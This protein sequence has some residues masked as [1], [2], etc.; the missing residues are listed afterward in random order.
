MPTPAEGSVNLT[1]IGDSLFVS[2]GSVSDLTAPVATNI[3]G[4]AHLHI[5]YAGENGPVA[6]P[7]DIAFDPSDNSAALATR[8][9]FVGDNPALAEAMGQG[10][11]YV[12]VHTLAFPGGEVR[13][14]VV[15]NF[16]L[17]E[18]FDAMLYGEQQNP[19]ILTDGMGGVVI[20]VTRDSMFVS[21]AFAL[22][23]PL[24]PIG[25]TGLH[26]HSG[27]F[28]QNGAVVLPLTADVAPDSLSGVLARSANAFARD[29]A[30]V[31]AMRE[32]SVYVNVHSLAYPAG[33]VRGQVVGYG[34]S[35]YHSYVSYAD[36]TPFPDAGA[37]LRVL[38][39]KVA[40]S[41]NV[42]YS[43]SYSGWGGL[44]AGFVPFLQLSNPQTGAGYL[45]FPAADQRDGNG[46]SGIIPAT[47]EALDADG[48]AGLF[49]R[50]LTRAGFATGAGSVLFD[51]DFA[52]ECKRVF[53]AQT[54]AS[55]VVPNSS[56]PEGGEVYVEYYG[57]R[58]AVNAFIGAPGATVSGLGLNAGLAGQVGDPLIGINAIPTLNFVAVLPAQNNLAIEP[59]TAARLRD[60]AVYVELA[61]VGGDET[62]LRGQLLPRANVVYH[63]PLAAGQAVPG[64]GPSP[65]N[66]AIVAEVTGQRVNLSGS[67]DELAGGFNPA[68]AGG[69]H[70]HG[71]IAGRTGGIIAP[72][73]TFAASGDTAGEFFAQDNELTASAGLLDSM[74]RRQVYVNLHSLTR[75]AGELRGQVA[76]LANHVVHGKLSPDV[77]LPYTGMM[78]AS[79]GMGHIH[80]EVFDTTLVLSGSWDSLSTAVDVSIGGG[81]HMHAGSVA[82]T[83]GILFPIAF[84]GESGLT[85]ATVPATDNVVAL[86]PP[87]VATLVGGDV[88]ANVHTEAAP[89]G[90][91]R[92]QMLRS[93]NEYPAASPGFVFPTAGATVDLNAGDTSSVA[94]IDWED[95]AANDPEQDIA[96]VWQLYADTTAAPAFQTEINAASETSLTFVAIDGLLGS[97]GVG[98][99][100]S[101]TAYH[102]AW[103]T[104]GSLLTPGPLTEVTFRRFLASATAELPAGAVALVNSV[105]DGGQ[106]LLDVNDLPGGRLHYEIANAAG[107]RVGGRAFDHAGAAQRYTLAD[108]PTQ[109]GIYTLA[110][111]DAEGRA[112][113]WMFV[114]R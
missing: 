97:L 55:Q 65:A 76:P 58:I 63:A 64:Q 77:T 59:D 98:L 103:T 4:G 99:G 2:S 81:A 87:Q 88:Y 83:G 20:E 30:L 6:L 29:P 19:P 89:S 106:L 49:G 75:P 54:T 13:G 1:L 50:Y 91:I 85:A 23:A 73:V 78:G 82:E 8:A 108:A 62:A 7:I 27:M 104:D 95:G 93:V 42:T 47:T 18:V 112:S 46:T 110:V 57:D 102:R 32:R 113:A 5:G 28:G 105:S 25:G 11:V 36:P 24:A 38:A 107:Q 12:N 37:S 51:D 26:L 72:L 31:D 109:A 52:H 48:Q 66:G 16:G 90:A 9:Y 33:E 22:E 92:G 39:E 35:V 10:R 15:A 41:D 14:Q 86:T 79:E 17:D 70:L 71:N 67:F 111:R 56:T 40:L 43:G 80:A 96:Y 21:G 53:Y 61:R 100:E 69:A 3:A 114:V 60:R 68:I 94:T 74:L 34:N 44:P 101:V 45:A 84:D